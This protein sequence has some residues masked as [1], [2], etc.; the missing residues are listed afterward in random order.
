VRRSKVEGQALSGFPTEK[1]AA[2]IT[3]FR[4]IEIP[5]IQALESFECGDVRGKERMIRSGGLR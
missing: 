3:I 1:A 2:P 5:P 4:V